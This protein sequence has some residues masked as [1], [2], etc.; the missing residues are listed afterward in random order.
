MALLSRLATTLYVFGREL[1]S[2]EHLARL[3][4]VHAEL[5][6]DRSMPRDRRTWPAFME[7]CGASAPRQV[8]RDEALRLVLSGP[9]G[10]S[11]R[12]SVEAARRA[13]QSVR[14]SLSTE[15]YEQVNALYW[16][17][18]EEGWE[19]G[20]YERLHEVELAAQLVAGLVE[21]T[22]PH[23][24][25]WDFLHLGRFLARAGNVTRVVV[26]KSRELAAVGEDAVAW[27]S[28]LRCLNS[29]EAYR[30]GVIA[31]VRR[32]EVIG[33]LLF[34]RASPRSAGFCVAEALAS[35]ERVDPGPVSG[36]SQRALGR[37]AARFAYADPAEVARAPGRFGTEFDRLQVDVARAL[38]ESY[39]QP[40]EVAG[41]GRGAGFSGQPQQQQQQPRQ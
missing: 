35:V 20:L 8:S 9:D 19:G 32:E 22:M 16:R 34:D 29:F 40:L 10:P 27:S 25:A 31:E 4:R 2:V 6:L 28:V 12:R 23:D 14:P 15:V 11:V 5:S 7:L 41:D 17:A 18:L 13:A 36:R 33:F 30:L 26:R 1:E 39:F 38:R 24:E 37:L 21:D 3:T